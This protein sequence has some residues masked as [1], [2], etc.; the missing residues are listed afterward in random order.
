MPKTGSVYPGGTM[1]VVIVGEAESSSYTR[2][3]KRGMMVVE[4]WELGCV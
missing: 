3:R 4:E 1:L 2:K